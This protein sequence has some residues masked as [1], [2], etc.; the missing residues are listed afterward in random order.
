MW[1]LVG[2]FFVEPQSSS[3]N[4]RFTAVLGKEVQL[5]TL[6]VISAIISMLCL[7]SKRT[8]FFQSIL[9]VQQIACCLFVRSFLKVVSM[10]AYT[11]TSFVFGCCTSPESPNK[12]HVTVTGYFFFQQKEG[13]FMYASENNTEHQYFL[14]WFKSHPSRSFILLVSASFMICKNPDVS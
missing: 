3:S 13:L 12:E 10:P 14:I 5:M 1:R 9:R 4:G 8:C 7:Q 11:D 6:N 2:Q